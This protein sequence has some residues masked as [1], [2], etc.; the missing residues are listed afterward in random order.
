MPDSIK[1]KRGN[2]KGSIRGRYGPVKVKTYCRFSQEFSNMF[3]K[4]YS[5]GE[6]IEEGVHIAMK[7]DPNYYKKMQ[8]LL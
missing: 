2:Q 5:K 7:K 1:R 4:G 8:K 6:I 3:P